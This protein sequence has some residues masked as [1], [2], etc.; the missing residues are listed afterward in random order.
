MAY[1]QFMAGMAFNNASLGY[2][3][4]MAHQLVVSTTFHT[5]CNAIRYHTFNA[6]N[7]QV[8]MSTWALQSD[9]VN[10]EGKT[11]CCGAEAAINA[12]VQLAKCI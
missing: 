7:A 3:H 5:V 12:I 9:G 4:A 1:A 8:C 11:A 10:V 2:V 6:T